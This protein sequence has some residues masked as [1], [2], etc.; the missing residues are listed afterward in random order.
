MR[1]KISPGGRS[2]T[3]RQRPGRGAGGFAWL[4]LG[5]KQQGGRE[6]TVPPGK[7]GSHLQKTEMVLATP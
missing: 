2:S 3:R 5:G 4:G 6:V 7:L 1:R